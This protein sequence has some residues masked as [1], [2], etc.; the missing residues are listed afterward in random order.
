MTTD[1]C[2]LANLGDVKCSHFH[3]S[4]KADF[5][6]KKLCGCVIHSA[7]FVSSKPAKMIL[8][9]RGISISKIILT[10][11]DKKECE[12][13]FSVGEEGPLGNPVSVDL[14]AAYPSV[15]TGNVGEAFQIQIFYHSNPESI[16]IQWL[17]ASQTDGGEFPYLFTQFQAIHCR[18]AIPCQDSPSNKVTY[19]ADISVPKELT[20]LMSAIGTT[21]KGTVCTSDNDYHCFSFEQKV[22]IPTYLVALVIGKLACKQ[23][24]PRTNVWTEPITLERAAYE[25]EKTNEY[26]LESEKFISP[27]EWGR[28]D[29]LCLPGSFPYGGMENP[30]LTFV[31]PTLLAGDQSLTTVVCHEIAHSWTGNLV[32][33]AT[34]EHFWLNEGFTV[35][36]ERKIYARLGGEPE[37]HFDYILGNNDLINSIKLFG[38]DHPFTALV[39]KLENIDPDE[40]FSS[41]PYEKG[42]QF[43]FHLEGKVGV[44][45][46]EN[47]FR[48][49][50]V[51]N[52]FK[53][54]TTEDFQNFF[55]ETFG[56]EKF[57]EIDWN[58]WLYAPG[59]PPV[60]ILPLMDD[61]LAVEAREMASLWIKKDKEKEDLPT[62]ASAFLKLNP[63][64]KVYFLEQI[65]AQ[66][67]TGISCEGVAHIGKLFELNNVKNSEIR[68]AWLSLCLASS[69]QSC[70][71]QTVEFISEQGRMK[72]VRPLY[73][74]LAKCGAD[75]FALASETFAKKKNYYHNIAT[76][77]IEQ[78]LAKISKE[79]ENNK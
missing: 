66:S 30:C 29:L 19:S 58:T 52:R 9:S 42:A 36:T 72:F 64:Q 24:G 13:N 65:L 43:L 53:S 27:Y 23:V 47:F 68:M 34:W 1:P 76:K 63:M 44:E 74:A 69:D 35:F 77:M 14:T 26:L 57:D 49:W 5:S 7:K 21:E 17:E 32:T 73:R 54:V 51:T 75:G 71:E 4:L 79:L 60:D 11:E 12:L 2:S 20:A 25:F 39:P 37:R 6:E 48:N 33:N 31:T 16:G 61:S 62:D 15:L 78:D 22:P 50:I 10:N 56:Q 40:A 41:I 28:Y 3:L 55:K 45:E 46:F 70:F 67:P 8:D 38:E 59:F 18:T